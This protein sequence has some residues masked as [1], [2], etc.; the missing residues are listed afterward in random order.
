[1]TK[2][3]ATIPQAMEMTGLGRSSI[4]RLFKEKKLTPLKAGK[5][6]LIRTTEIEAFINSLAE[7][8]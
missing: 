1:M 7:A 5:R 8:A 3:A 4:Y 2:L 6:T